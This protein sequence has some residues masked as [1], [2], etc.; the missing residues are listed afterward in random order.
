[1]KKHFFIY[2]LLT[3]VIFFSW[4]IPIRAQEQDNPPDNLLDPLKKGAQEL[5]GVELE[6]PASK[7][8]TEERLKR[9]LAVITAMNEAEV[10]S[11]ESS[12][13]SML[14]AMLKALKS[15]AMTPEEYRQISDAIYFANIELKEQSLQ[16]KSEADDAA[17]EKILVAH[18][19]ISE[20]DK[21]AMRQ[22]RAKK[23]GWYKETKLAPVENLELVDRHW[24]EI[25]EGQRQDIRYYDNFLPA[26]E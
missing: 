22:A 19:D 7:I 2:L 3:G 10:Q 18:S 15:Q 26:K 1:M 9:F 12:T 17:F 13:V 4:V 25:N 5:Q 23:Q 20:A 21:E 8:I 14:E 11:L 24:K 6:V 16:L